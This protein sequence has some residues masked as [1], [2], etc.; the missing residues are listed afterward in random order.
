MGIWCLQVEN[1]N[2]NYLRICGTEEMLRDEIDS[3]AEYARNEELVPM[4]EEGEFLARDKSEVRV[5]HGFTD[6]S[7]RA[8]MIITF[9]QEDVATM[10]LSRVH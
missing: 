5:V 7:D 4:G 3:W 9:L 6:T 8:E 10:T 1:S 2:G